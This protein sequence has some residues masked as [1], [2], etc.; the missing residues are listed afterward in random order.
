MSTHEAELQI[1][2]RA[3]KIGGQVIFDNFDRTSHVQR[4]QYAEIVTN[5]D[6]EAEEAILRHLRA[7]RP[8]YAIMSEESAD[9]GRASADVDRASQA[10]EGTHDLTWVVD[11]LD[12][13]SNFV[14]H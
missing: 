5:V 1:A 4:K 2:I 6:Y 3:A 11:P 8:A 7:K 9:A 12:G 14:L 10:G 13:T